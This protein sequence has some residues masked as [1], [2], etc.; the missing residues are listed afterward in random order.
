[1]RV[2]RFV[3]LLNKNQFAEIIPYKSQLLPPL[4]PPHDI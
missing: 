2:E 1:M 4:I 3:Y